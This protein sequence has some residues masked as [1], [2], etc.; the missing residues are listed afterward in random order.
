M[1]FCVA[2]CLHTHI[3]MIYNK[4]KSAQPAVGVGRTLVHARQQMACEASAIKSAAD[5]SV[6][7]KRNNIYLLDFKE[8]K[9]RKK[10]TFVVNSITRTQS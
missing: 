7:P 9:Q 10:S 2:M 3:Y 6:I 8:T 1:L 4:I 5:N